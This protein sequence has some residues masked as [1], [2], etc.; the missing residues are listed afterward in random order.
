MKNN[1]QRVIA[2]IRFKDKSAGDVMR[3]RGEVWE[4]D[5]G[6]AWQLT[7]SKNENNY[8]CNYAALPWHDEKGPRII[9]YNY[10]LYKIG[11]TETFL[12][13]LCKYYKDKN[14][15][16]MYKSGK[17]E[18]VELLHQYCEVVRDDGKTK[19]ACDVLIM[20]NYFS[21]EIYPRVEAKWKYQM[22]HADYTGMKE[23]GWPI[24]FK[25]PYDVKPICVSD[26]AAA[27]LK[28]EFGYDSL[29]NYNIL[30]KKM[31]E[32]KPLIFISLTR[33]TREKG[34]HRIITLAKLFRQLNKP[35]MWLLCGT[36]AEQSDNE[37]V[38]EIKNIPEILLI[39]PS[40]NNKSLISAADY[41]VQLS[42][43]ESFCYSA[44]EALIM[45]KPVII[46]DFPE[47]KNIVAQG[48]NGYIIP[49]DETKYDKALARKIFTKIPADITY[50]DR[51]DY[52]MWE[53]IFNSEEIKLEQ[54]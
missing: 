24:E 3:A 52:E 40:H 47:A 27:G 43:T 18:Y 50:E 28:R 48:K 31:G 4:V 53:K 38:K 41:L 10:D 51:C 21:S 33:A 26:V 9:I 25:K 29:V 2:N 13:N 6:R 5:A 8:F 11:G 39:P 35:F 37:I 20:G 19:Y 36:V 12:F 32:D 14:I 1:K 42:D 30:D 44:Y 46:T 49:R 45:G 54:K 22:I 16:V 17:P 34:I 23:A 15:I 7:Q